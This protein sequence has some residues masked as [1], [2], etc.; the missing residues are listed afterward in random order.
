MRYHPKD[1][2]LNL[3]FRGGNFDHGEPI[4]LPEGKT[5]AS[6]QLQEVTAVIGERQAEVA[7]LLEEEMVRLV[8]HGRGRAR[9]NDSRRK[10]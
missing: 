7:L 8:P 9:G 3:C 1:D 2:G 10:R 4:L 5:L 6:K